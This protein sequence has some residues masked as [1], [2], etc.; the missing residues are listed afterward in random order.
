MYMTIMRWMM[1]TIRDGELLGLEGTPKKWLDTIVR[2]GDIESLLLQ[3]I[4]MKLSQSNQLP[5]YN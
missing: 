3:F 5:H 1:K 4:S 2:K